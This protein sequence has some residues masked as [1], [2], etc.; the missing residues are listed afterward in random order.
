MRF[1]TFEHAPA[2]ERF[3]IVLGV[4]GRDIHGG[5]T[6]GVG[7]DEDVRDDASHKQQRSFGADLDV[8]APPRRLGLM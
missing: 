4:R 3:G 7:V 2:I 1:V 5:A 6:W 8:A